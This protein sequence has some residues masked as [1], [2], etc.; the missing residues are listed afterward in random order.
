MC[1]GYVVWGVWGC[2]WVDGFVCG[3]FMLHVCVVSDLV[4]GEWLILVLWL[5]R[6]L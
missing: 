2:L 4:L 6:L 3:L 5:V 1:F